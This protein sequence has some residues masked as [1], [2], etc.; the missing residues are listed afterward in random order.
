M[1]LRVPHAAL[2]PAPFNELV[3]SGAGHAQTVKLEDRTCVVLVRPGGTVLEVADSNLK[4]PKRT[5]LVSM[6]TAHSV[7]AD[8]HSKQLVAFASQPTTGT[9]TER[10]VGL[11]EAAPPTASAPTLRV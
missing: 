2:A 8:R 4:L 9:L 11:V 10:R 1:L 6:A 7:V 5:A 3:V